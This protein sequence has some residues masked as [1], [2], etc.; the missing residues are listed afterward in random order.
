MIR[1]ENYQNGFYDPPD[2]ECSRYFVPLVLPIR[3]FLTTLS[4]PNPCCNEKR[5]DNKIVNYNNV[6]QVTTD[7]FNLI[8]WHLSAGSE[9]EHEKPQN[10][11]CPGRNS[12]QTAPQ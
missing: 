4:N 1:N 7:Y 3:N 2:H 12:N 9:K 6:N 11:L 5:G 10:R 8:S